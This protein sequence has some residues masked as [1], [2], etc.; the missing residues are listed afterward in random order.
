MMD[1]PIAAARRKLKDEFLKNK[2][3]TDIR[4][5]DLLVVKGRMTFDEFHNYWAQNYNIYHYFDYTDTQKKKTAEKNNTFLDNF[6][7]SS[8]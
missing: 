2:D 8:D 3:V 4:M 6:Y 5:I 1:I 7:K